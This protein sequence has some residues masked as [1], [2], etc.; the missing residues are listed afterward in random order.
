[1]GPGSIDSSAKTVCVSSD[2][3]GTVGSLSGTIPYLESPCICSLTIQ[4][5][6]TIAALTI[7]DKEAVKI[8]GLSLKVHRMSSRKDQSTLSNALLAFGEC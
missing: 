7:Q 2:R 4:P 6:Y 5:Y 3:M 1:M 8:L